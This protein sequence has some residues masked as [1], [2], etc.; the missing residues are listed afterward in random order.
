MK[1]TDTIQAEINENTQNMQSTKTNTLELKDNHI[2][3]VSGRLNKVFLPYTKSEILSFL[4]Q[5][6]DEYSSVEDVI[7]KEFILPLDYYMHHP[8]TARFREAYSL[9]RDREAK[10]A[11]EAFSYAM[12]L[13]FRYDL[14]PTIIA[15]CKTQQQ[16]ENY[17]SCLE[18]NILNEFKDFEIRFEITPM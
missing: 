14:N 2:L 9:I 18:K 5:Y 13:M 7:N 3:I 8:I 16:L 10:N 11:I 1:K 12:N 17:I 6:P 4:E 15:A